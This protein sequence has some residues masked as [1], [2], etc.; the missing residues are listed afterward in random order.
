VADFGLVRDWETYLKL[1]ENAGHRRA[2]GEGSV[3]YFWLPAA[4]AAI[5]ARIPHARIVLIL[6]DPADR[7]F[8]HYL[9]SVWQYPSRSFRARFQAG[10]VPGDDWHPVL[11]V[12]RY[13]RHLERFFEQFPADQISIHLYEDYAKHPLRVL[14][15]LFAFL[16]VGSGPPIDLSHRSREP[17]V[18]RFP[19]LHAARRSLLGG[20]PLLARWIPEGI[21][22]AIRAAYHRPRRDITMAPEDRRMVIEHY[23]E[24]ILGTEDLIGRDLSAWL[25]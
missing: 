21:K 24:E 22:R 6:R 14:Q 5:R 10:L 16:G 1:F 19:R 23:R 20:T 13:A 9:A 3:S 12:G 18:P 8:S 4:G 11:E 2:I 7:L 17:A 15:D 25:R